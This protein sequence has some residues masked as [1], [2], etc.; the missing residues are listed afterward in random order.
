MQCWILSL[1]LSLHDSS[2]P[3]FSHFFFVYTS[4]GYL[5]ISLCIESITVTSRYLLD[6]ISTNVPTTQISPGLCSSSYF[7]F[8][9]KWYLGY[10]HCGSLEY[11]VYLIQ[12]C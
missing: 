12:S 8:L 11:I 4:L 5:G 9:G 10:S 1:F 2:F 6:T 3:F 7:Y